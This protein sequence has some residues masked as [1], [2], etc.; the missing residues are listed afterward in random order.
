M[1][2]LVTGA[3]RGIGFELA[4]ALAAGKGNLVLAVSRNTAP[5]R[6]AADTIHNLL[7]VQADLSQ[8]SD[9]A[10][11]V[12]M[13]KRLKMPLSVMVNNA[14]LL[15]KKDFGKMKLDDLRSMFTTNVFAPYLLVQKLLPFMK[16]AGAHVVNIGSMGGVQGT[17]KFPGLSGYSSSKGALAVLTECMAE[18]LR[19]QKISVNCLALGSVQ[20]EMLAAAFPGYRAA[21]QPGEMAAF[22]AD[23]ALRG[24]RFFNGKVIPVSNSTP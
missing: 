15:I 23:F 7:P 4:K 14:G 19:A 17:A 16:D 24:S 5:L 13:V 3:S 18:E 20:T 10:A 9:L 21:M 8:A 12:N 11:I 22:I 1:L 2:I 6:K